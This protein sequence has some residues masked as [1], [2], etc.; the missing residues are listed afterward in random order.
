MRLFTC[1]WVSGDHFFDREAELQVLK[2]RFCRYNPVLVAGQ[3]RLGKTGVTR[4]LGRQLETKGWAL[5]FSDVE[6]A[7]W[8]ENLIAAIAEAAYPIRP[9]SSQFV[10]SM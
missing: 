4:E 9:M 1:R 6:D 3:R 7:I 5:L 2:Y 10:T 8:A